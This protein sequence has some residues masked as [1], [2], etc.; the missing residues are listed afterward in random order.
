MR[1]LPH[2]VGMVFN[3]PLLLRGDAGMRAIDS[4]GPRILSGEPVK[5]S[6]VQLD[7]PRPTREARLMGARNLPGGA[8]MVEGGI[9]V[10]PIVGTLIRRGSWLDAECGLMSYGVITNSV[11]EILMDTEVRGLMLEIDSGGGEAGGCFDCAEF[12]RVASENSGKPVWAHANEWMCSAAYAIGSS[13]QQIWAARTSEVGSIGVIAAHVDVSGADKKAGNQWT[14][15]IAG[16]YKADG[17]PHQPLEGGPLQRIQAD[18]DHLYSMFV[19]LVSQNRGMT[20]EEIR[21]TKAGIYRGSLAM[22]AGLIDEVGTLD[23]ALQAFAGHIDKEQ[24]SGGTRMSVSQMR[25]ELMAGKGAKAETSTEQ[26]ED[27]LVITTSDDVED[28]DATEGDD[29]SAPLIPAATE[30]SAV[31]RAVSM[32][33]ER[34][35]SLHALAKQADRLGITFDAHAAIKSKMSLSDARAKVLATAAPETG[36]GDE[37]SPVAAPKH[38]SDKTGANVT[39]ADKSAIWAKHMKRR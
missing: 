3:S 30:A 22:D 21:A 18:V 27:D 32:E 11:A 6:E 19:E 23:E 36:G 7:T 9:A 2:L 17:N 5:R 26:V 28:D 34:C 15:V 33:T 10:L 13:G 14:Y 20:D 1:D 24:T 39:A 38:R 31:D 16:E 12:I 29:E 8:Y 35:A 4:I 25:K 37:V